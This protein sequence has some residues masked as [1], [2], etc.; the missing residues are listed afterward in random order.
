MAGWQDIR[1]LEE[2]IYDVVDDYLNYPDG[3]KHPVLKVYLYQDEMQYK[4]E[5]DDNLDGSEDEG[6][7]SITDLIRIGEDGKPE[8]NVD[9]ISDIANSWI[10]ID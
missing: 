6:I 4:A 9:K 1:A 10:F 2:R 7:Y 5:L 8:P 3:Y